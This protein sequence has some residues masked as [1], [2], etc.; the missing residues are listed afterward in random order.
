M[1]LHKDVLVI[2]KWLI[3]L[4][5]L[6]YGKA[7]L[8]LSAVVHLKVSMLHIVAN[9]VEG[10][11]I[12]QEFPDVFPDNLPGMPPERDIEF[13]PGTAPVTKSPYQMT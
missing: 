7:T 1:K 2:A 6:V 11:A 8:H 3:C 5:S 9:R 4:D 13:Q 12:V 10:I